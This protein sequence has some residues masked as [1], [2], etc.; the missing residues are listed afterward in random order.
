[1]LKSVEKEPMSGLEYRRRGADGMGKRRSDQS[2]GRGRMMGDIL[3]QAEIDALMG[4]ALEEGS[5]RIVVPYDFRRPRKV[6]D[7][8]LRRLRKIHEAMAQAA[9]VR[10][11]AFLRW[12]VEMTVAAVEETREGEFFAGLEGPERTYLCDRGPLIGGSV[13]LQI[14]PR[15]AFALLDAILGGNGEEIDRRRE[16]SK[17]ESALFETVV[18]IMGEAL[19]EGWGV[20]GMFTESP[21][22]PSGAEERDENVVGIT[23][24][25]SFRGERGKMRLS[26]LLGALEPVLSTAAGEDWQKPK[27][28]PAASRNRELQALLGGAHVDVEILL[29]EA[30]M[31]LGEL[32]AL[33]A[34]DL[35]VLEAPAGGSVR[36]S[37]EGTERLAGEL[38]PGR[39]RRSVRITSRIDSEKSELARTLRECE[40]QRSLSAAGA[41]QRGKIPLSDEEKENE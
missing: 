28:P 16:F 11:E 18:R 37:V 5:C 2:G 12:P 36:V 31:R 39:G 35:I 26:Y 21:A 33:R 10:L 8:Q 22:D 32:L 34:G 4:I 25:V 38:K 9:A 23:V 1:M 20:A 19:G 27:P 13:R 41:A 14:D 40:R 6:R 17:M 24:A 3:S 7:E 29:G 30:R 15:I